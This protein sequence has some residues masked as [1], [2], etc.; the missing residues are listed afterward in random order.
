MEMTNVSTEAILSNQARPLHEGRIME[1]AAARPLTSLGQTIGTDHDSGSGFTQA[2]SLFV[3][4]R[5][6]VAH[7]NG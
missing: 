1:L 6:F 3:S 7:N 2:V 5:D 4:L